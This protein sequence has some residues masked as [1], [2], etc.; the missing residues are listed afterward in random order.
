MPSDSGTGSVSD[1]DYFYG[2]IQKSSKTLLVFKKNIILIA[3][4]LLCDFCSCL[5]TCKSR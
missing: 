1:E 3:D 2:S 5:P 4:I